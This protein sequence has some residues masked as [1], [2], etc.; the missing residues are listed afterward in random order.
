MVC[1]IRQDCQSSKEGVVEAY[2]EKKKRGEWIEVREDRVAYVDLS[3]GKTYLE[4]TRPG[5]WR[6]GLWDFP[7]APKK[8]KK[9]DILAG[10][11]FTEFETTHVVT[12][13]KITRRLR[14]FAVTV[15]K[16]QAPDST[17]RWVTMKDPEVA[18]GSAPARG[19]RDILERLE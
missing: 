4:K 8:I 18:L 19:I 13:H 7:A 11:P 10:R 17:G 6:A 5:E 14:V 16:Y 1:P 12:R 2:P 3:R 9:N 15:E